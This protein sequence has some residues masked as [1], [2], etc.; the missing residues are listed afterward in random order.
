MIAIQRAAQELRSAGTALRARDDDDVIGALGALLAAW[1]DPDGRWQ[2]GLAP[3]LAAAAG[4]S[5]PNVR[6]GLRLALADWDEAALRE[7]V[8]RELG[9]RTGTARLGAP[10]SS[11]VCAGA[12]PMPTLLQIVLVLAVRSPALVKPASRDPVT[13]NLVAA[14]LREID[15]GLAACV[16]VV[17]IDTGDE[18]SLRA[19]LASECVV[20]SGADATIDAVRS[21]LGAEQ[22]FV[23]YGHRFSI[24]ALGPAALDDATA[25]ALARDI[26]LWDQRGCMSPIAIYTV[27]CSAAARIAFADAL[28]GAL[29]AR[30]REAPLG[31]IDAPSGALVRTERDEARVRLAGSAYGRLHESEQLRWT[32]VLETDARPRVAPLHRFVR[33]HP[34]VDAAEFAAVLVP[35]AHRLSTAALAGVDGEVEALAATRICEPG[36]MQRPPLGV[37]HDGLPLLTP[38]LL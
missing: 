5:E 13:P 21:R 20:A 32:V 6:E 25:R 17:P 12:I 3:A 30:E 2:Q 33:I 23:G 9:D 38:L 15:P 29:A 7:L 37:P 14:S 31:E 24:A 4:F 36:W 16:A 18:S 10:L 26:S 35:L 11:I 28:A 27:G 8:E 34:V 19:F 1:R 22:R